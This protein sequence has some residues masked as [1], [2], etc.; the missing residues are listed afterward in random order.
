MENEIKP[1]PESFPEIDEISKLEPN[2]VNTI[3][4]KFLH[5]IHTQDFSCGRFLQE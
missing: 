2:S 1:W 3:F 4:L 5:S